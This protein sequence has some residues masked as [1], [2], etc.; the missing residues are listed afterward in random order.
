MSDQYLGEIRATS[1]NFAPKG[2]AMCNGQL[3]PIVQNQALFALLGTQYGGNGT[4]SFALPDLRG[5]SPMHRSSTMPVGARAG[6]EAHTLS[7]AEMPR[8]RHRLHASNQVAN[9]A[10]PAGALPAAAAVSGPTLYTQPGGMLGLKDEAVSP[11]GGSQPH[12]NMQPFLTL[13]FIIALQGI[14]PSQS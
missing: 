2:W 8:H 4:T 14:F 11:A 13:N 6:E 9:S 7:T 3:L 12:P 5:R 1:F 10:L